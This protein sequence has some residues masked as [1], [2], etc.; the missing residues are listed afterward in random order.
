M[1]VNGMEQLEKDLKDLILSRYKS[2]REFTTAINLPYSTVDSVLKRGVN[3]A[4]I[5]TIITICKALKIDTEKL[6]D[7]VIED[8]KIHSIT[9]DVKEL[10]HYYNLLNEFGKTEAIKRIEELTHIDKY[11]SY[12][13]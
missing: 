8:A 3:K 10:L 13:I 2:I 5:N 12:S 7:G 9:P 4:G 6:A 1:E 11:V